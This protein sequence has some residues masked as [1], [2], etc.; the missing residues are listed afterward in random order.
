MHGYAFRDTPSVLRTPLRRMIERKRGPRR[1]PFTLFPAP[2]GQR[3]HLIYAF[4]GSLLF[5]CSGI[6]TMFML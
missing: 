2:C 4:C 1:P 3:P 6:Y 5:D